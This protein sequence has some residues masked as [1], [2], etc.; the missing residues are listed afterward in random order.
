MKYIWIILFLFCQSQNAQKHEF[1]GTIGNFE[2]ASSF[3]IDLNRNIFVTDIINNTVTK[4][5]SLGNEL[6]SVGGYGWEESL[7]DEPTS[8]ITNTLSIYVSDKNND[9][10]Q[11]FDKDLNFLSLFSGNN[12]DSEINFAYPTCIEISRI[13]DLF[14]LDTDN[15]RILKFSL[16]GEYQLEI[17]SNDAGIYALSNPINFTIDQFGNIFVLDDN[18]VKVFD[19]Y[20]NGQTSFE[21]TLSAK[22][23]HAYENKLIYFDD[24]KIIIYNFKERKIEFEMIDLNNLSDELII[25]VKIIREYLFVLTSQKI[26][27]YTITY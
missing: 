6:I 25:D 1:I 15:N 3:D 12:S 22:G 26:Y 11:R 23:I 24:I 9:R 7:F 19:Q 10:I 4:L 20:G 2:L 14:L 17:G 21:L 18:R 5:D 16:T 8:I 27:K 13:G